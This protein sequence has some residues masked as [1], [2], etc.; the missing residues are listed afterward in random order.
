MATQI[1]IANKAQISQQFVSKILS[2]VRR[3]SWPTAKKL[4]GATGTS[5]VLW[6]EG[7]PDEIRRAISEQEEAAA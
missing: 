2:G 5:P 4:A 7:T 1:E 6:L 3:P